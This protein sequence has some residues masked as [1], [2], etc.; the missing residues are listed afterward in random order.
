M[1][2]TLWVYTVWIFLSMNIIKNYNQFLNEDLKSDLTSKLDDENK[3]LKES[4]IE[5]IIKSLN[6]EDKKVFDEINNDFSVIH[7][8]LYGKN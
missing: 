8:L 7:E 1:E 3:D 6:T 5:K 4:L 2:I